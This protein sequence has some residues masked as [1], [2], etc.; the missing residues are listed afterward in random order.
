MNG[1]DPVIQRW[2]DEIR[3][4]PK[5]RAK[6]DREL[7]RLRTLDFDLIKKLL[8]GPLKG[9]GNLYKLRIRCE[10]RELRPMLCRGPFG[11]NGDYTLLFGARE[12]G[13]KLV[14][15]NAENRACANR[16]HLMRNPTHR[17]KF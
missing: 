11:P 12:V 1:T 8:A 16:E 5:E 4:S 15:G 6:F 13:D 2:F 10:T 7:N 14:P 3:I 9:F 17:A